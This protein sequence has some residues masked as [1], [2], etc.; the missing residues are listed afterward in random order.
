MSLA[1]KEWDFDDWIK[2]GWD[3]GWCGPVVC[4]SHDGLPLT[5]DEV[6]EW[7]EGFD[8]CLHVIRVY[9]DQEHRLAVE[10]N[11]S[12]TRWR[13]SNQGWERNE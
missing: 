8:P 10:A 7:G 4:Y 13:A 2:F 1:T 5:A 9:E 6:D 11:D 3:R 12:P